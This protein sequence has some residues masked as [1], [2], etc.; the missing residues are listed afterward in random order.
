MRRDS[1]LQWDQNERVN[2]SAAVQSGLI[3]AGGGFGHA[4]G[5]RAGGS[6]SKER[7]GR[8]AGFRPR[9]PSYGLTRF[10][11]RVRFSCSKASHSTSDVIE[12]FSAR[13]NSASRAWSAGV[14]ETVAVSG[15]AR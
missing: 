6:G 12:R 15:V 2:S 9:G 4:G 10:F 5:L 3:E 13:A 14:T 11:D 1:A 7:N 8:R